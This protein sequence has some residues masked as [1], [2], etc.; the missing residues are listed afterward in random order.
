MDRCDKLDVAFG[1]TQLWKLE[2]SLSCGQF[3]PAVAC[4]DRT[5]V[6]LIVSLFGM[7]VI[8]ETDT[9]AVIRVIRRYFD[10]EMPALLAKRPFPIYLIPF[11]VNFSGWHH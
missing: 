1:F 5:A 3:L 10:N 11:F 7:E 8:T 4:T 9:K 6:E 2:K